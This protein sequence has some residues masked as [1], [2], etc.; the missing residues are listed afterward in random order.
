MAILIIIAWLAAY[1]FMPNPLYILNHPN[2]LFAPMLAGAIGVASSCYQAPGYFKLAN[3]NGRYG[4]GRLGVVFLVITWALATTSPIAYY[5]SVTLFVTK[6]LSFLGPIPNPVLADL[7]VASMISSLIMAFPATLLI[8]TTLI[9]LGN[10]LGRPMIKAGTILLLIGAVELILMAI[11]SMPPMRL[12]IINLESSIPVRIE[13]PIQLLSI[14]FIV[15]PPTLGL[16]GTLLLTTGLNTSQTR[17]IIKG[18]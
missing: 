10:D 16:I 18:N 14:L 7:S 2:T 9:R 1:S 6:E 8:S 11:L 13:I 12:I 5:L 3:I 4:H 15:L 17:L